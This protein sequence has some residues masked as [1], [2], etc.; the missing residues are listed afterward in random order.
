MKCILVN[1]FIVLFFAAASE[2]TASADIYTWVGTSNKNF[3]KGANWA[4]DIN[5]S[6]AWKS[7]AN[8][9]MKFSGMSATYKAADVSFKDFSA[10][11]VIVEAESAGYS[12]Y[13]P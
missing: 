5:Y 12:V 6:T 10:A 1:S 7:G 2:H 4:E 8:N 11:G 3:H 13:T 9:I